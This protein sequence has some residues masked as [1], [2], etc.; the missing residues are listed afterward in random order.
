MTGLAFVD[1]V[2][3]TPVAVHGKLVFLL[4][5]FVV[6]SASALTQPR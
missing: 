2:V 3:A 4:V 5:L 1:L 6:A